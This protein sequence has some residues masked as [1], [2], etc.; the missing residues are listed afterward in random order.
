[1]A[2]SVAWPEKTREIHNVVFDSSVWDDFRF[3]DDDIV[4]AT[5]AKSGTTWT[6]QI[7]AQLLF[8]GEEGLEVAEMSPWLDLCAPPKEKNLRTSRRSPIGDSSRP[9]CL[10]M[11]WYTRLG[12]STSLSAVTAAMWPRHRDR[13]KPL[14]ANSDALQFR[15]HEGE[16]DRHRAARRSFL[17]W[18]CSD[19]HP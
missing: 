18:L 9:I 1:M 13:P 19:L 12:Q 11:R 2:Q 8:A 15:L 10:W 14:A 16:R 3:R 4:I 7:V 6:Q 17:G 5:W